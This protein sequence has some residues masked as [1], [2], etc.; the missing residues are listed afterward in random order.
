MVVN[1]DGQLLLG[2]LLPNNVQVEEFLNFMGLR[3]FLSNR[4]SYDIIGDDLIADI[5]ALIAYIYGRSG[6]EFFDVVL[7]FGAE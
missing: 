6:N 4:R 2:Y 3:E 1:G 7:A 5:N